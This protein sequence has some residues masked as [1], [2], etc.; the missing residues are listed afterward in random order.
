[1]DIIGDATS[2]RYKVVLEQA[3][4][5]EVVQGIC[6]ILTT[7]AITDVDNIADIVISASKNTEKPIFTTFIGGQR[8]RNAIR[9]L[10]ANN[11]ANFTDPSVAINAYSK[12]IH[13]VELVIRETKE[14]DYIEIPSINFDK[15]G[16][17]FERLKSSGI[18]KIGG[19]EAFEI[20]SF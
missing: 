4:R 20:L 14:D 2:E 5:D 12:L 11:I 6:A 1:M 13:F 7:Q 9:R 3:I 8:V 16:D 18:S 10:K 15:A 19:E 17:M